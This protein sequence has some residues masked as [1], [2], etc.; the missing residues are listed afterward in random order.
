MTDVTEGRLGRRLSRILMMLP[1]AIKHPGVT[2]QELSDRFSVSPDDLLADL[3]LVFLCGLPGYDPGDLIDVSIDDDRVYVSM[4]DYFAAP[5]RL[6]PSEALSLYAG[7]AALAALPEMSEA[8]ALRRAL[9]KLGAAIGV[10][11]DDAGVEIRL[12][13]GAVDQ[14]RIL[15]KGLQEEKRLQ[16]EYLSATSGE[17][18]ER[19]VD[20]WGL[21]AA[22]G[23]WYLI[24][25][26]HSVSDE[27]MFRVDRM[28]KVEV[29]EDAAEVP[30]DFDPDRYKGAFVDREDAPTMTLELS[31]EVATWFEDYYPTRS[32]AP[33][34]DGWTRVELV[35]SGERWPAIL[36][37]RLGDGA[38]KVK[39][40][41]VVDEARRLALQTKEIYG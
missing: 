31:P 22:Q 23:R 41:N 10:D 32:S 11:E 2:V 4:A 27:R 33:L 7:G 1:Y 18:R 21:V 36:L 17:L 6:T 8:D 28:K 39:P 26:D 34:P 29:L 40:S 19:E 30:D 20:P 13:G 37:L 14:L 16:L 15:K 5:L 12:E 25:W 24:A 38:R 3:N 35:A 9:A